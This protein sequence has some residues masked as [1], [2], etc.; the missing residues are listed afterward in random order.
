MG[1]NA[2]QEQGHN[3]NNSTDQPLSLEVFKDNQVKRQYVDY[4]RSQGLLGLYN[5]LTSTITSLA[6]HRAEM[7]KNRKQNSKHGM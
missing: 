6:K 1:A 3:P 2:H 7:E 5:F 4:L